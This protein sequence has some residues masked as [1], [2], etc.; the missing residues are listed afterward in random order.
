MIHFSWRVRFTDSFAGIAGISRTTST[1]WSFLQRYRL[2]IDFT[3]THTN[4]SRVLKAF[5][6]LFFILD[7]FSNG[8]RPG[9]GPHDCPAWSNWPQQVQHGEVWKF[10]PEKHI[11]TS[12]FMETR[13]CNYLCLSGTKQLWN[14]RRLITLS[15][16]QWLLQCT[17]WVCLYCA[18]IDLQLE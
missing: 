2:S 18:C 15:T 13:G 14:T 11:S 17:L 1:Y 6:I 8:A 4:T 3:G 7:I 5:L 12:L 9:P 16:F 10:Y